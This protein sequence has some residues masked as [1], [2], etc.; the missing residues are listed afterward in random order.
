MDKL[1]QYKDYK[2]VLWWYPYAKHSHSW[3]HYAF[4]RAFIYL[5]F[6]TTW[7]ENKKENL[8]PKHQKTIFI[9]ANGDD[10]YLMENLSDDWFVFHHSPFA[11]KTK[12]I[13]PFL[14]K[15]ISF[16]SYPPIS[17]EDYRHYLAMPKIFWATDLL[18]DEIVFHP[19]H[20]K[21]TK[22]VRSDLGGLIIEMS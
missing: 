17:T 2:V 11:K 5:G 18:P 10:K 1:E 4:N 13:I 22:D 21:N 7:V 12:N 3:I 16:G 14:V 15:D 9:T 20:Y 6:D 19:Y 8:P